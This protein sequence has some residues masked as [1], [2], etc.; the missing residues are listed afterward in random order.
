MFGSKVLIHTI[1]AQPEMRILLLMWFCRFALVQ[2]ICEMV[3]S[4]C[5]PLA[6]NHPVGNPLLYACRHISGTYAGLY[7]D[8]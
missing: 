8:W 2:Q 5:C 1:A 6:L 3:Q 7:F 4:Q